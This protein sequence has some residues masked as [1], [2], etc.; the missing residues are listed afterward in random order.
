LPVAGY[1]LD[2]NTIVR[3]E[4]EPT[5]DWQDVSSNQ[6][7]GK[8]RD[9]VGP[10]VESARAVLDKVVEVGPD[11]VEVKFGIKVSGEVNWYVARASTDGN[12]EVTLTWKRNTAD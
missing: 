8:I 9:A 3:F 5:D 12:F 1:A 11:E 4:V 2:D 6:V 7:L 10:A